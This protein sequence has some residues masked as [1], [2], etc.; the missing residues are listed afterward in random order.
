ME[1]APSSDLQLVHKSVCDRGGQGALK[2]DARGT[3]TSRA[4]LRVSISIVQ[5]LVGG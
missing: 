4:F 1:L 5:N 3:S 2:I